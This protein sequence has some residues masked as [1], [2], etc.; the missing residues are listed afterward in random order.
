MRCTHLF[1]DSAGESHFDTM[2]IELSPEIYAPPAPPEEVS[3][4]IAARQLIFLS[5]PA[6]WFGDWHPSPVRQ[7]MIVIS[8]DLEIEVSDGEVR[9]FGP[10]DIVFGEDTEGRGHVSR[11]VGEGE[12]SAAMVQV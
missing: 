7:Y 11:V 8:G 1:S 9:R 6:G 5:V 3:Q 2:E 4:P 10:G 12:F